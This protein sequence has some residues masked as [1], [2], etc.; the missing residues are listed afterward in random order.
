[1]NALA[2]GNVV[3]SDF[4]SCTVAVALATTLVRVR[5]TCSD[6]LRRKIEEKSRRDSGV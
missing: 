2:L 3:K 1:M 5:C 4:S 6:L